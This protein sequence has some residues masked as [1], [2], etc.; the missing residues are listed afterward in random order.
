[1]AVGDAVEAANLLYR[2]LRRGTVMP[3]DLAAVQR[4]RE[5]TVKLVQRIQRQIQ[6]RIAGPSLTAGDGFRLPW[7]LRLLTRI[8]GIRDL[9]ARLMLFG[10]RP[11]RLEVPSAYP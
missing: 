4:R 5:P 10:L 1:M 2:P 7:W 6:D 8:P 11:V 9:P 3:A